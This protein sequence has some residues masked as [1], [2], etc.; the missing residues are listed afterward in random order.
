MKHWKAIAAV[1]GIFI[2]GLICGGL[3]TIRVIDHR[4][5]SVA[6]SGPRAVQELVV[7]RLTRQLR[8]SETQRGQVEE[9][10]RKA[11]VRLEEAR[12]KIAPEIEGTMQSAETEIR[13]VLTPE[14]AEKFDRLAQRRRAFWRTATMQP[15][16][17]R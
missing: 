4:L 10:T 17:N 11:T 6:R 7:Q 16:G 8:L 5:E 14:Q 13:A 2:L 12:R 3:V 9:I 1:C 15:A